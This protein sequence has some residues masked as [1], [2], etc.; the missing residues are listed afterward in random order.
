LLFNGQSDDQEIF[1]FTMKKILFICSLVLV[2]SSCSEYQDA[3][4]TEEIGVKYDIATKQYDKEK[5]DKAIRLFEQIAPTYRGRPQ[6]EKMFYMYAQSYFKTKQYYSAAYQF[7]SFVSSYPKS[8]KVE[9]SSYLSAVSYSKLSPRYSLDQ[10]D[11]YKAIEKLQLFI[12]NY[13]TSEY[14]PEANL[15]V[16]ELREKL[17]LK[18]FEIAKQYNTISDYK[19]AIIVL[20]NFIAEFPGTKYK[21]AALFYKLDS[22]YQLAINSVDSKKAER[23]TSAKVAYTNMMKYNI[24]AE[25]KA[26]ADQMLAQIEVDLQLISNK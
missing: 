9:E 6:A 15:V 17:E 19:A 3:L 20:D 21:G 12:N 25:Y 26:K 13:P 11:S 7:E 2:F 5:Y 10:V 24:D 23:L 4:K 22:S 14:L 18:S 8:E 1:I 16:K